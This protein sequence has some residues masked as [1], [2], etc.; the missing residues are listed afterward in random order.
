MIWFLVLDKI[1][2]LYPWLR[3]WVTVRN[4]KQFQRGASL[5]KNI[6]VYSNVE[7]M[8]YL[9]FA[10]TTWRF[11]QK[12][13]WAMMVEYIH[14]L[15]RFLCSFN[16]HHKQ[17][18][19]LHNFNW[20]YFTTSAKKLFLLRYN[21]YISSLLMLI[22]LCKESFRNIHISWSFKR[23]QMCHWNMSQKNTTKFHKN[24]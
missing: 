18:K 12:P 9:W 4:D 14:F 19:T 20:F 3:E 15:L 16:M 7:T 10:F 13:P 11:L 23:M 2:C 6:F 21:V 24:S 17:K 1:K 22:F 8:K 5:P